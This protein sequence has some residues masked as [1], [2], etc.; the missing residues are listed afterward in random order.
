MNNKILTEP[1][2]I[3]LIL[4]FD[5]LYVQ[6]E[7]KAIGIEEVM[8]YC[9]NDAAVMK[10]WAKDQ[11]VQDDD[12]D[13]DN[14]VVFYADPTGTVTREFDMIMDHPG[15]ISVGLLGRCKRFA[16]YI[17]DGDIK[18]TVVAEDVDFDPAGDDFPEKVLPAQM[19]AAI[20]DI[21]SKQEQE[22]E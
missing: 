16:M 13:N 5:L 7:L 8:L 19:I 3:F 20:K 15:P 6:T 22:Q 21:Q 4:F 9:V 11:T 18:Y 2:F 12:N 1:L 17:D 10:A 14:N